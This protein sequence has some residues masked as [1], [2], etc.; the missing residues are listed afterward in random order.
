MREQQEEK[1]AK[2]REERRL[3]DLKEQEAKRQALLANKTEE[4]TTNHSE[5][6]VERRTPA[7]TFKTEPVV[8]PAPKE[9]PTAIAP[10]PVPVFKLPPVPVVEPTPVPVVK[11]PPVPVVEPTPVPVVKLTPAPAPVVESIPEPVVEP[12]P[13][14]AKVPEPEPAPQQIQEDAY[15]EEE[16]DAYAI[17]PEEAELEDTGFA[18]IA[19]Y[20]YQA[21]K[22]YFYL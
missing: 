7:V 1:E 18:A 10:T 17:Q 13:P 11:L 19:L 2:E 9:T 8:E 22:I 21:G 20:D 4:D 5:K 3:N 6:K 16:T 12:P 15:N 14:A